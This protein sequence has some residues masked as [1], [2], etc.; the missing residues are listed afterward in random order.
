VNEFRNKIDDRKAENYGFASMAAV[1]YAHVVAH[2]LHSKRVMG[3]HVE[4]APNPKDIVSLPLSICS[5]IPDASQI[6]TNMT[7]SDGAVSRKRLMGFLWMGLVGFFYTIPLSLIS[8]L[9][10]LAA[11]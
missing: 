7:L 1:P 3:A 10:N 6:W 5:T 8:F 11:V 9:A 2:T 4:L